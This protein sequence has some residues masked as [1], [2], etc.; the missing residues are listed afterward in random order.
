MLT[1][2]YNCTINLVALLEN[3]S[4]IEE[5]DT[6]WDDMS[7]VLDNLIPITFSLQR[8]SHMIIR[9]VDNLVDIL[10]KLSITDE[11]DDRS[12]DWQLIDRLV[13][14]SGSE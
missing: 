4:L 5:E 1:S 13:R 9:V 11:D 3:L 7:D 14:A 2:N 12:M 10:E 8:N 6:N